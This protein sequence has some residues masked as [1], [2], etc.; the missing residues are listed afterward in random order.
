MTTALYYDDIF[1]E[2]DTGDFHPESPSRLDKIVH[3]MRYQKLWLPYL[4]KNFP[5]ASR[6]QLSRIHAPEY[7]DSIEIASKNGTRQLDAD[8]WICEHSFDAA[9]IAAGAGLAA[10]KAVLNGDF[11]NALCLVRPPG[12]HAEYDQAMGFCL[13]NNIAIAAAELVREH[14][15]NHVM[16]I[17]WDAHHG[18]GTQNSFYDNSHVYYLSLHQGQLFPHTGRHEEVGVEAGI[19]ANKNIVFAPHTPADVYLDKFKKE[20]EASFKYY[21]P[22][23][24]LIS[25]G[26]D[27]HVNDPLADL[28][29]Q[30]EHFE[31]MTRFVCDLSENSANGRIISFLEG[32]YSLTAL[33]DSVEAHF[34]ALSKDK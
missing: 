26:F 22:E 12:H 5:K 29:L 2:H 31:E 21:N 11:K 27:A 10:V 14:G 33:A 30:T 19:G 1:L 4:Q 15:L 16:I 25:A 13:F 9:L 18:N 23:F 32:G 3:H 6:N 24:V 28:C 7:I 8:T 17:D 20:V 34:L